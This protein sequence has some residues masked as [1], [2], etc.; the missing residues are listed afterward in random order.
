M[1]SITDS[2]SQFVLDNTGAS[3]LR[4]LSTSRRIHMK[5]VAI[6]IAAAAAVVWTSA[7]KP[8]SEG[9]AE[10]E[11]TA[12]SVKSQ[13]PGTVNNLSVSVRNNGGQ[14][15]NAAV[16]FYLSDDETLTT[17]PDALSSTTDVLLHR[18][19]L[20]SVQAGR[21]KKKTLG[22]GHLKQASAAS[23]MYVIAYVDAENQLVESD[24][25]NNIVASDPLP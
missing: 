22:G 3:G 10:L 19:S 25:L 20:G 11:A 16:E 4:F 2:V 21:T 6:A 8:G 7:K 12:I 24:E 17:T 9:P 14:S 23:G 5:H 1:C 15:A 18:V 13:T